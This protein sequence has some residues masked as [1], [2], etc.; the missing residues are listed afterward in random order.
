MQEAQSLAMQQTSVVK[1]LRADQSASEATLDEAKAQAAQLREQLDEA[2]SVAREAQF[3]LRAAQEVCAGLQQQLSSKGEEAVRAQKQAAVA[4]QAAEGAQL[5]E[6]E[7]RAEVRDL[8]ERARRAEVSAAERDAYAQSLRNEQEAERARA[9]ATAEELAG[10]RHELLQRQKEVEQMTTLSL[11]GDAT[12]TEYV[13]ALKRMSSTLR[14]SEVQ[15]RD[16][17]GQLQQQS[18]VLE[19][20]ASEISELKET[21]RALDADR[22]VLQSTLDSKAEEMAQ[23]SD[24]LGAAH[25]QIDAANRELDAAHQQMGRV[26]E[27]MR[28]SQSSAEQLTERLTGEQAR[29]Q[30]L[31]ADNLTVREELAAVS[32]DLQALVRENQIIVSQ[33]TGKATEAESW[34][35]ELRIATE[36]AETAEHLVRAREADVEDIRQAYESLA[37]EQQQVQS[38]VKTLEREITVRDAQLTAQLRETQLLEEAHASA[39]AQI[40]QQVAD[41]QAFEKAGGYAEPADKQGK[42]GC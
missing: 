20:K 21:V 13:A 7:L 12:I 5:R 9:R 33:L 28:E 2:Q 34:R 31:E 42:H 23:L 6:A 19:Q 16:L 17:E 40:L 41:L 32:D 4:Q 22:D 3:A 1:S 38:M 29:V 11:K 35:G 37:V 39:Q 15:I 26:E 14:G 18:M 27:A 24:E 8:A 30:A 25:S 10:L 36:R